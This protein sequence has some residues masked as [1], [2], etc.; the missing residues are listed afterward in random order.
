MATAYN[1]FADYSKGPE[2]T[3]VSL[4]E[5]TPTDADLPNVVRWIYFGGFGPVDLVDTKGNTVRVD[6]PKGT[7]LGPFQ[8]ARV[9]PAYAALVRTHLIGYV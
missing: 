2:S 7:T 1:P 9:K 8:V 4:F 6:P 5:I 3:A